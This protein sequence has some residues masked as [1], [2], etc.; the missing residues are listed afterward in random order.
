MTLP[1][2][3]ASL[4]FTAPTRSTSSMRTMACIGTKPHHTVELGLELFF[5]GIDHDLGALAEDELFD[6]QEPPQVALVDLLGVHL[7]HLALVEKD[8][9]EQRRVAFGHGGRIN[10]A[11]KGAQ[12]SRRRLAML[13]RPMKPSRL[14]A[15][16]TGMN[17]PGQP[18]IAAD[19]SPLPIKGY[20]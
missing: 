3:L 6:F 2:G 17:D 9:F 19:L 4:I 13:A 1:V 15:L 11:E 7:E 16:Q 12:H 5:A 14:R 10:G 20:S 18:L 8:H